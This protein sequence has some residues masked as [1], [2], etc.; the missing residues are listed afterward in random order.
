MQKTNFKTMKFH[1][2]IAP[3]PNSCLEVYTINS[4]WQVEA[5]QYMM[6]GGKVSTWKN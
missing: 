1:I 2:T 6:V 5:K 4:L 3:N